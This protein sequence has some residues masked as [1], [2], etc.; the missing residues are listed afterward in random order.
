MALDGE[1][2]SVW[3]CRVRAAPSPNYGIPAQPPN[4]LLEC[5]LGLVCGGAWWVLRECVRVN[6]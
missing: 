4:R 1:E 5:F 2:H 3:D 6:E